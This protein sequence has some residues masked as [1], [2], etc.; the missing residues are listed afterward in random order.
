M[1]RNVLIATLNLLLFRGGPQDFPYEPRLT[2]V[3]VTTAVLIQYA[4]SMVV[5][6]PG[7]AAATALASIIALALATQMLLRV[8]KVEARFM[9]TYHALLAVNSL[10][11]LAI[12]LPFA[13]LAPALMKVANA[14]TATDP[15]VA[16]QVPSGPLVLMMILVIWN[17]VANANIFRHA[18]NLSA[19]VGLFVALLV[20]L[21]E[22][23]FVGFFGTA[24]MAIFG[25]PTPP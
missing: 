17:F 9:Q 7:L 16:A 4:V 22:Q 1:F 25:S 12:W 24:A 2:A 15:A 13:E 10:G 23:M 5:M 21:G 6:P 19:G 18:A 14:P 8:R 11:T 20:W 3:L